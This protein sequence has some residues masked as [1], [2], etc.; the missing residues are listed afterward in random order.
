MAGGDSLISPIIVQGCAAGQ[1]MVF[2]F[3]VQK[4]RPQ[5]FKSWIINHYPTNKC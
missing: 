2:Y 1:G 5:L 3:S 4:N